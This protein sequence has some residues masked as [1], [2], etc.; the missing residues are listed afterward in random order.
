MWNKRQNNRVYRSHDLTDIMTLEI[1]KLGRPYHRVPK[2]FT[3]KF[4]ILDAKLSTYFLK[5]Y[6]V[7]VALHDLK[8]KMDCEHKHALIFS[9]SFGNIGFDIDR[10]LLLNILNDYYGLNKD[11]LQVAT[12]INATVTKTEERLKNKLGLEIANLILDRDIFARE[13]EI[14]NDYSTLI[15]KWSYK[16]SFSLEGYS[17]GC[18]HILLDNHHIDRLLA[19]LRNPQSDSKNADVFSKE[20]LEY[21]IEQLPIK[22]TGRL[23][24]LTLTVEQLCQLKAGDV[25]SVPM[26]DRFPIFIGK[27]QPFSAVIAE[28]RGKLFFS[29]FNDKIN[30]KHYD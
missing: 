25:L 28:D 19:A 12:D 20:T 21:L 5:K 13:L 7:N 17:Q 6:R 26:P 29:E 23:S 1:N 3:D 8:F 30:E 27:E 15:N 16:L 9:T 14:K 22:L 2:I 24:N 4:D 11:N 18:L 10:P